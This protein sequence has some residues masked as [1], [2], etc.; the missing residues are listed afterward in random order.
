MRVRGLAGAADG[1]AAVSQ[2]DQ[3][4]GFLAFLHDSGYREVVL[5]DGGRWAGLSPFLY[6]TAIVVGRLGDTDGFDDRW[7]YHTS[8]AAQAALAA[9]DGIG[10]PHGWHRQPGTGRRISEDPD[11]VDA[12]GKAVGA[13]G[14][15][16]VRW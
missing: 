8:E 15:E 1:P 14:V 2:A 16:Y 5:L 13:V 10:E 4:R 12:D 7:C 6:T 9:W 11:E 3:L